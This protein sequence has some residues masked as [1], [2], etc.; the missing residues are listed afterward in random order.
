MRGLIWAVQCLSQ[1]LLSSSLP[2]TPR[3][4]LVSVSQKPNVSAEEE[5]SLQVVKIA[6]NITYSCDEGSYRAYLQVSPSKRIFLPQIKCFQ[7]QM[8]ALLHY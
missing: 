2:L 1:L 7:L 3:A 4:G 8:Q 5:W 6:V